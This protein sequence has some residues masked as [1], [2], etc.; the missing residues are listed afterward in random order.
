MISNKYA[1][2]ILLASCTHTQYTTSPSYATGYAGSWCE[3]VRLS[4]GTDWE[5]SECDLVYGDT[6][7]FHRDCAWPGEER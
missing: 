7:A 5:L 3:C 2:L 1:L 4:D 6:Y